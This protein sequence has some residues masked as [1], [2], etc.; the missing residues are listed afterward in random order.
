M[1]LVNSLLIVAIGVSLSGCGALF[2]DEG[3]FPSRASDYLEATEDPALDVPDGV[4]GANLADAYPVPT[5]KYA[6][7]LPDKFSVPRV[8]S[9]GDVESKG[10]VRIQHLLDDRWVLVNRA[11]TQTWPL[12]VRF[13]EGNNVQLALSDADAGLIETEWLKDADKSATFR[14]RY[15]YQLR[16]GVQ[17]NTTEVLIKQQEQ[18]QPGSATWLKSSDQ[19]REA[20]MANLLAQFLAA[21][22]QEASYSLL[23][24]GISNANKANLTYTAEGQ[25]Y[26]ALQLPYQ[27]GWA[28]LGLALEKAEFDVTDKDNDQGLYYANYSPSSERQQTRRGWFSRLAFWRTDR[29]E[30]IRG[31]YHISIAPEA[32]A[33]SADGQVLSIRIKSNAERPLQ[34][35][36][37]AYLLNRI[38]VKLS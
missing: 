29:D 10:S 35:N 7:V 3:L 15:R 5:L 21:S 36:E 17:K 6:S 30:D 31:E 13:L 26:I 25:P 20:S 2:G 23:A 4:D 38:L 19:E 28:S 11:P 33:E 22:P 14:E 8:E 9:L 37:Q 32:N 34:N 1:R 18:D 16:S 12:I 27:R 24:Q